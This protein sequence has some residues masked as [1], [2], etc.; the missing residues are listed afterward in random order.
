MAQ[1]HHAADDLNSPPI[2]SPLM[3]DPADILMGLRNVDV[4]VVAISATCAVSFVNDAFLSAV[5]AA[6]TDP[7]AV[8]GRHYPEVFKA[9]SL[10]AE[11]RPPACDVP[12]VAAETSQMRA[13]IAWSPNPAGGWIGIAGN[14]QGQ[15]QGAAPQ[16]EADE[17]TGLGNRKYLKTCFEQMV[18]EDQGERD[19]VVA[20]FLDLDHFKQVNDT[21]GHTVGDG[22]LRKVAERLKRAIRRE[23]VVA[24]VGGDEF[25]ILLADNPLSCAEDIAARIIKMV[26]RPFLIDGHQLTIG[27]SIGL[28]A[29]RPEERDPEKLLQRADIALY[30]SKRSG[31]NQFSWFKDEM[32]AELERRRDIEMDLRKALLLQQFEI[33][34]QPQ[35]DFQEHRVTGFEAL[36]RWNHPDMGQILPSDFIRI[37]EDTGLI[38]DIGAWVLAEACKAASAWPEDIAVAVNV[39][40]MQFEDS[41]F[42]NAV[43]TA[44][45]TSGLAPHRLELEITETT[46]LKKE[47]V[48]LQRM[49]DLRSL[50]IR[51]SLDDFGIGYSSL[52]YLRKYPFDKVKIDQSFVREPFADDNAHQIVEAVAQLGAAFGMNVLAEGVETVEQ[53]ARIRAN[54]CASIQGFLIGRPIKPTEIGSFLT[55]PLPTM[56]Q[57]QPPCAKEGDQG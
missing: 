29:R 33:V 14:A 27:V 31:R 18:R 51:I 9:C 24:R 23:D 38:I 50:G 37:A 53:L 22:L 8:L 34:F 7:D 15:S 35:V 32:F 48:V 21:L 12:A 2:G 56:D 40:S 39:S 25:A 43:S 49:N 26:S 52:N 1:H 44:L 3:G 10:P 36:I 17:L 19:G 47:E 6:E 5:S 57:D 30:E 11:A 42:V 20:L 55:A 46:L 45:A 4:G 54:G 41:G 16:F 28:A 13:D